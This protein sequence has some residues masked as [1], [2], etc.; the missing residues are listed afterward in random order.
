[1]LMA[2]EG[3]PKSPALEVK[4]QPAGLCPTCL[5]FGVQTPVEI[6]RKTPMKYCTFHYWLMKGRE[7]FLLRSY[8]EHSRRFGFVISLPSPENMAKMN[9][10]PERGMPEVGSLL[11]LPEK[12]SGPGETPLFL[13]LRSATSGPG[14]T[15]GLPP[16]PSRELRSVAP[17]AFARET[18][19]PICVPA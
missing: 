7:G 10:A 14:R 18:P 1:L 12:L 9:L 2:R 3:Q 15:S 6:R 16:V 13:P 17:P 11:T 8:A 5:E 4:E 19:P